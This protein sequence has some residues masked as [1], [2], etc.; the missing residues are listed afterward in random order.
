MRRRAWAFIRQA[1]IL[2]SF[3][4]GLPSMIDSQAQ[5][6]PLPRNIH[7]DENFHEDTITL[8]PSLPD[9]EPTQISYLIAKTKLA[10]GF[11]RAVKEI[12]RPEP[13]KWE[14]ILEIDRELRT[15]YDN[16]PEHYKLGPLSSQDSLVLIS[17]R[18]VLSSIHHKSLC[19]LHSRFLEIAKS[20]YRYLYSRR[21]CLSSA[22]TILRFQAIQNQ[23]IPVDGCMRSL[24]NYQ[25]SLA[26]HHYLLA[27]TIISADLS[28]TSSDSQDAAESHRSNPQLMHGVPSRAELIKA[29]ATSARI[30][31]Q[32]RDQSMEAYKA[33]D[34]LEMLVKKFEGAER[35]RTIGTSNRTQAS[36]P[37]ASL[38]AGA[39]PVAGTG[40]SAEI[41]SPRPQSHLFAR[42]PRSRLHTTTT[43]EGTPGERTGLS[44]SLGEMTSSSHSSS[45]WPHNLQ[46]ETETGLDNTQPE[47]AL[48]QRFP[49]FETTSSGS[50]TIPEDIAS[51]AVRYFPFN[52]CFRMINTDQLAKQSMLE[53]GG[54]SE[55]V[56][57]SRPSA[58]ALVNGFS[59]ST[60]M[61]LN[62]PMSTLWNLS[63]GTG[64]G[65]F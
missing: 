6:C 2:L 9:S 54:T 65:F 36:Q 11:A 7:D 51:F 56:E 50:W 58:P 63:S 38:R 53:D 57:S 34:V 24:T 16:I 64:G 25:T 30:F 35:S 37:T 40:T 29:L 46:S 31:G 20:D 19:V 61:A 60:V 21:L 44:L 1:D 13:V 14:R 45:T 12:N 49:E 47:P 39:G 17:S 22:M 5:E 26:I 55:N 41:L 10:F 48:A 23:E 62:D 15:I 3:Q 59:Y 4:L 52:E 42:T 27:A 32:M 8:P 43:A 33:A 28:S 18:F